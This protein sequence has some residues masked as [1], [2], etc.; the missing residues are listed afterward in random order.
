[1]YRY[2]RYK[3]RSMGQKVDENLIVFCTF[4]GKSYSDSPKAIYEYLLKED[5][6]YKFIWFFEDIEKYKS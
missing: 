1:M 3:L 2:F 6:T 4:N 5:S